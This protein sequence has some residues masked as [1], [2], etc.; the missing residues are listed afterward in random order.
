[1]K[2][3]TKYLG[4]LEIDDSNVIQ[5]P[6][7]LPGFV[8]QT[9]FILLDLPGNS[10]FQI[11]QSITSINIAFVVTNP[12]HFYKDYE[13][14]LDDNLLESIDI[15]HKQEVVVYSIVTLK[16]PF[17]NSTMNLKAPLILN[18]TNKLGKQYILNMD[19]YPTNASITPVGSSNRKGE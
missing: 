18:S 7:G 14:E 11:L 12:Y 4:E 16:E 3:Q 19:H 5:F 17:A 13:F 1:M 15:K 2:I 10:V 9:K 8:D 6:S